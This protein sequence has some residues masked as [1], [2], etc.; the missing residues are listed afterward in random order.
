VVDPFEQLAAVP[1]FRRLD[2]ADRRHLAAASHIRRYV[3]GETIFAEGDPSACFV[4]VLS[5]LVKITK[6]TSAGHERMIE[7]LGSGDPLGAV[8][9]YDGRP[10]PANAV[11]LAETVCL[12]TPSNAFLQLLETHPSL[13]RGLLSGLTLRMV[14]LT[15]RL[16]EL[17]GGRLEPRFARLFLQLAAEHGHPDTEGIR[18]DL[19]L[20]RQELA[21]LCGTTIESAIRI[22][23]RWGKEGVVRT[24]KQGFLVRDRQRLEE[25]AHP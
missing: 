7:I 17:T 12:L 3:R 15:N 5:G 4:V 10:Y 14:E 21:D 22:L 16:A 2:A 20:S 9:V 18:I 23:S 19:P 25:L 6:A 11:A 13:V 1:M 8:A 24:E